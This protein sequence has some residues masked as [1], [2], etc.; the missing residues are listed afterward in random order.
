[1]KSFNLANFISN[2]L[3]AIQLILSALLFHSSAYADTSVIGE[4]KGI[5]SDGDPATFIFNTDESAEILFAG[6]P[7]LSSKNIM[8]GEVKWSSTNNNDAIQLDV[9]IVTDSVVT[10]RIVMLAQVVDSKTLK[11]QMSRDMKTR[12][13]NFDI[14]E[15]EFQVITTRQ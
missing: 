15:T 14:S 5:D 11:I 12:P 7:P 3:F 1:M 13:D 8:N 10:S 4:W 9:L 2:W 6:L